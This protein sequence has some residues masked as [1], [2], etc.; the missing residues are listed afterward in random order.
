MKFDAYLL[1]AR[2]MS[3][4]R[5]SETAADVAPVFGAGHHA[6]HEVAHAKT[7]NR[8]TRVRPKVFS[9]KVEWGAR[10]EQTLQITGHRIAHLFDA[11]RLHQPFLGVVGWHQQTIEDAAA[12][13]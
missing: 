9:V 3:L 11:A 13:T 2:L 12:D 8:P 4:N 6:P 5:M 7:Q 10:V 1:Q